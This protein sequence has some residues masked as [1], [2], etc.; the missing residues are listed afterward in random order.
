MKKSNSKKNSISSLCILWLAL[1]AASIL[2]VYPSFTNALAEIEQATSIGGFE[3]S[4]NGMD[5]EELER[6][7]ERVRAYNKKIAQAQVIT[8]FTYQG[9]TLTDDEYESLLSSD[10][11]NGNIMCV[12]DIPSINVYLPVAHGTSDA[13]LAYEAGHMYGTSLPLG[14]ETTHGI[15]AAHTGLPTARLFSDVK[16]M[17]K[18]DEFRIHVLDEIH[19]YEVVDINIVPQ[20]DE[21]P[22]YMQIEA[23]KDYITLYTCSPNGVNTHRIMVKGER[24]YPDIPRDG[25]GGDNTSV[26][27][28]KIALIKTILFAAIPISVW[29][30]GVT[31]IAKAIKEEKQRRRNL[32]A[33]QKAQLDQEN[34]TKE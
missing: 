22:Q 12:V 15:I 1:L 18:G 34:N 33:S 19:R 5:E 23:E 8:P 31:Q 32:K 17:K 3:S 27:R 11:A 10:V 26:R 29:I 25:E 24:R 6:E 16:T 28:N 13:I 14:G 21:E 2:F 30:I 20:G 4:L 9:A 7:K